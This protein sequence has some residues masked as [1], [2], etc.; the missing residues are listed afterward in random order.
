MWTFILI[1][2]IIIIMITVPEHRI[3]GARDK[4]S[5][6]ELRAISTWSHPDS[7]KII[8]KGRNHCVVEV[9]VPCNL[10]FPIQCSKC[11]DAY[12]VGRTCQYYLTF[13]CR[14]CRFRALVSALDFC[15][16]VHGNVGDFRSQWI[17]TWAVLLVLVKEREADCK[18]LSYRQRCWPFVKA[19]CLTV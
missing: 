7:S 12:S 19:A 8:T 1:I 5:T 17:A 14:S 16:E 10:L 11:N 18:Y 4:W 2:I 3:H 9:Q 13:W 6:N 15:G